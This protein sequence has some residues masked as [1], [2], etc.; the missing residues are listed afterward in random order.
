MRFKS[1]FPPS[2]NLVRDEENLVLLHCYYYKSEDTLFLLYKNRL[3]GK[4]IL[5][6]IENP[7]VPVFIA[8]RQ[9]A[10]NLEYIPRALTDRVLITYKDKA[11]ELKEEL[12][13]YKPIKFRDK[14][15]GRMI[16][17][18]IFPDLPNRAELLHPSLF[19]ADVPIEQVCFTEFCI[20]HYEQ[21]GEHLY[22]KIDMPKI[23][24]ASF[25]IETT[26]WEDGHWSINTNTFV[27]QKSGD[28]YIDF[29]R[30]YET[31]NKQEYLVNHKEA[32][33]EEVK[34][35]LYDVIENSKLKDPKE[36]SKVQSICREIVDNL[37]IHVR[38][39]KSEE[40]LIRATTENMFTTYSPD[41][42][43]AYNTTYDIGMFA[44][45]IEELGL[46]RGTMNQRNIGYDDTLPPYAAD[47]N[48][49]DNWKFRGDV[50]IPKKRKVYLNN[51]SHTMIADLQTCYY[52][53]RQ[54]SVYSSYKL[55]SLAEMV[56]GF[57]KFD[58]SHITN[59]ILKLARK[60]FW[61]HSVYALIDSIILI[62]INTVTDEF[63][64]KMTFVYRSKC[65]IEETSQSN[66][67][68]TRNFHTDAYAIQD[69]VPGCNK[70]KVLKSMTKE[71]VKKVSNVI[72]IDYTPDWRDVIYRQ[73]YGGGLV[74]S[75]NLYEFDFKELEPYNVLSNEA[76][77]TMLKKVL[78]SIYLDFKSHY[79]TQFITRNLSK[80]TLAGRVESVI[81]KSSREVVLTRDFKYKEQNVW[82]PHMGS[83]TLAMANTD[84]VSYASKT[85]NLPT[86]SELADVFI[87]ADSPALTTPEPIP[88]FTVAVPNKYQKLC[89]ILSKINLLRFTK[90]DEESVEKDNKMFMF[91]DGSLSYL[92]TYVNY[93][94]NGRD[95]IDACGVTDRPDGWY[96]GLYTKKQLVS[97]NDKCN[98]PKNE[99][100]DLG[101][102]EWKEMSNDDIKSLHLMTLFSDDII[103]DGYR[104][105][106]CDRSLY[107]PID[108]KI[109]QIDNT[110][111]KGKNPFVS[112][113]KYR[114][115]KLNKTA[116][117]EFS[118]YVEYEDIKVNITQQFQTVNLD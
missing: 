44:R 76:Q 55:D 49:D 73:A 26:R 113:I 21:Q 108:H 100:F 110:L 1:L 54:G 84:I 80:G 105:I 72:G 74:S 102:A 103:I 43:M 95:L 4:K 104:M 52:S 98:K 81:V 85:N 64:S 16:Y 86:M 41:I 2:Y 47:R 12:F 67:T 97:S 11:A 89:S 35:V 32:Y 91:T 53:A 31:Y 62:M 57:G 79:P 101:S 5:D 13:E 17:K 109:K 42:L 7:S 8:K 19:Y 40:E 116:K 36:R 94:W 25:D 106:L 34:R 65:N 28:A 92:G 112:N 48:L 6:R 60:D 27:D 69:K 3:T 82:R 70:N 22:E 38:D 30:D 118:Y 88:Q 114:W 111:P 15:T 20:N 115:I 58:Y 93:D 96:Y 33:A 87:P 56:L 83:I 99:K 50:A 90:T 71:D 9:P 10:R 18:K 66:S 14:R 68:I 117:W 107:Y 39:F 75:P 46:P 61:Y 63:V 77:L 78:D 24:F 29:V 23:D 51:I 59:D 37:K 45:R